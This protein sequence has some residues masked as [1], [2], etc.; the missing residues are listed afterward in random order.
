MNDLFSFRG[1]PGVGILCCRLNSSGPWGS[2]PSSVNNALTMAK[3]L[4][5]LGFSSPSLIGG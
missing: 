1:Q 2:C 4:T 5:A 3:P